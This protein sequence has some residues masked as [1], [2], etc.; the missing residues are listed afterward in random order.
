MKRRHLIS[1]ASAGLA[2][3]A[4]ARAQTAWP[5]RRIRLVVPYPPGGS[6]DIVAR[7]LQPR[8][9]ASLGQTIVIDNRGGASGSLG[10]G[11]VARA[12]PDGNTWLLANDTI[13]T[14]ETL[15]QLPYRTVDAFTF[16]T[17]VGTCPYALV[18]HR[19]QPLQTL[20]QVIAAAKAQPATL[21]YATTGVGS[22]AHVSAVLLEQ[23]GRFQMVHVP[24]RGGGPAL[25]DAIAG[26]VALFMSNIVI[27]LPHIRQ[28]TLVPLGVSSPTESRFLPGVPT[29]AQQGFDGFASLTYW[30]LLG[31]AGIPE[32]ITRRMQMAV[33]QA[34][35]EAQVRARMDELGADIVASTPEECGAFIRADIE[36]WG[37][38][39][40]ENNIRADS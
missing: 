31:P 29:F 5:D 17:V 28:G 39:I 33:A 24:Y 20:A 14:N 8:L 22:L 19:E 21:N 6:N 26:H 37:R 34:L 11:E 2:M 7:L 16:C 23:Q 3:P 35:G 1:L 36:K 25:Q 18:T 15:M 32:P 12:A 9:Q 30:T 13:A 40:R 38:V 4:V 10:A 27:I